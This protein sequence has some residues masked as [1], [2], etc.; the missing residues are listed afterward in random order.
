MLKWPCARV[1]YFYSG[2]YMPVFSCM[3]FSFASRLVE[4]VTNDRMLKKGDS[5]LLYFMTILLN[6]YCL[7]HALHILNTVSLKN[8]DESK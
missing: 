8:C 5:G 7:P 1:L 4:T 2:N 6:K 3:L